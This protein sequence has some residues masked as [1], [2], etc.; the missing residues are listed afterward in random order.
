[1]K[2]TIQKVQNSCMR[3]IYNIPYRNHISPYL[4]EHKILNM[5][6]RRLYHMYCFIWKIMKTNEPTYLKSKLTAHNHDHNTRNITNFVIVPHKTA[7]FKKSYTYIVAHLWNKLSQR[8]KR[9]KIQK[10][11]NIH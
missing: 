11:Y 7:I 3:Y 1:M 6:N 9:C 8:N 10:I 2:H 5:E 4:N